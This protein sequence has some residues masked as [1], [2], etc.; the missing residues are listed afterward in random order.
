MRVEQDIP[1]HIN[2]LTQSV[3]GAALEVHRG[4][5]PG[6][7]ER[8]Y[9]DALTYELGCRGLTVGRQVD[10][11]VMYKEIELHGQRLDL[12]VN[13]TVALE[14]KSVATVLDVHKAQLLSYLRASGLPVGLL[15]NFNGVRL[16]D[17]VHRLVNERS[18]AI[19][20]HRQGPSAPANTPSASSAVSALKS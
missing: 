5:G 7:L 1:G 19:Q 16:L 13:D 18:P 8:L 17:G 14:L 11:V 20:T 2:E 4:L 6:L 10:I 12:V 15:I 9:E 3:I